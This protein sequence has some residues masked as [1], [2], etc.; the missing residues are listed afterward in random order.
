MSLQSLPA[1]SS[2]Q[3]ILWRRFTFAA[4]SSDYRAASTDHASDVTLWARKEF[5]Y[6]SLRKSHS[7]SFT[8]DTHQ[9]HTNPG[10]LIEGDCLSVLYSSQFP[11]SYQ[12]HQRAMCLSDTHGKNIRTYLAV[13][14]QETTS[15]HVLCSYSFPYS[16]CRPRSGP[17]TRPVPRWEGCRGSA[18]YTNLRIAT[19]LLQM[20]SISH[21]HRECAMLSVS[22]C[23]SLTRRQYLDRAFFPEYPMHSVATSSFGSPRYTGSPIV[24][25]LAVCQTPAAC[26]CPSSLPAS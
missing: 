15:C 2:S 20:V 21:L 6:I 24:S 18:A 17:P 26:W 19:G 11:C 10:F 7:T 14:R 16:L 4:S 5:M 22:D 25:V 23:L 1:V 8:S 3:F 13:E 12:S 9:F